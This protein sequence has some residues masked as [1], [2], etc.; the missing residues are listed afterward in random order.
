MSFP[1]LYSGIAA[2]QKAAQFELQSWEQQNENE[3]QKI[4]QFIA[5]KKQNF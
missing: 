5:Q 2:K 1:I 3:K 4:I